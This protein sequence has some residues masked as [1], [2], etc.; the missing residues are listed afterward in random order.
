M[1]RKKLKIS[2]AVVFMALVI[3]FPVCSFTEDISKDLIIATYSALTGKDV[4]AKIIFDDAG[5]PIADYGANIGKQR[6]PVTISNHALVYEKEYRTGNES[7]KQLLLNCADWLVDNAVQYDNYTIWE[8]RFP[9]QGY[10]MTPPW[11]SGMAQGKGVQALTKAYNLTGD[12][13]YLRVARTSLNS[14]YI[15]VENG[16][17]T[18][19][20]NNGWWYEEYAD[21]NGSNP[22]VLNGMMYALLGIHEYY[23]LTG[24][25]NAKY[26]FDEGIIALKNHL[27][28]YDAGGWTYYDSLENS[29]SKGY[30]HTH[31]R[32]LSQL[33]NITND[34]IFK[35][36]HNKWKSYEDSPLRFFYYLKNIKW[37]SRSGKLGIAIYISNFLSLFILLEIIVFSTIRI[38]KMH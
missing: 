32:Q 31:V 13:R 14:F 9:W 7:C 11:R 37:S 10:N 20:E 16:G 22:R 33:Y 36:Y 4:G 1:N 26:L 23:E 34:P 27:S 17:V 8:Y 25:D 2:I 6:N 29:A 15:E 38:K 5:V 30:H 28:D 24:E 3:A 19:K 18:H 21:E 12:E 35:E